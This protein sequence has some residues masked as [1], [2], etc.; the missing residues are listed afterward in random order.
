VIPG[1]GSDTFDSWLSYE[2][3]KLREHPELAEREIARLLG[4]NRTRSSAGD[5]FAQHWYKRVDDCFAEQA[6]WFVAT[7]Q[8][9]NRPLLAPAREGKA[10]CLR[11]PWRSLAESADRYLG[12][13]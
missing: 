6:H 4:E 2:N 11:S 12:V 9:K 13:D 7:P 1:K 3:P 10:D 8:V 5:S